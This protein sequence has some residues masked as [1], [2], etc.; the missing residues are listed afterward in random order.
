MEEKNKVNKINNK[1]G[2]KYEECN[3]DV[4]RDS[5]YCIFH[6]SY[7]EKERK[8][9]WEECMRKFYSLIE[10]DEGNFRGFVLKNMDIDGKIIKQEIDFSGAEFFGVTIFSDASGIDKEKITVLKKNVSFWFAIFNGITYFRRIKFNLDVDFTNTIFND[11]VYLDNSI[12]KNNS[13]FS[14]VD[15]FKKVDFSQI[16]FERVDFSH[17][18]FRDRVMFSPNEEDKNNDVPTFTNADFSNSYFEK[19]GSFDECIIKEGHFENASIQNI[20]F[21]NVNLDNVCFS[22][23]KMEFAYLADSEWTLPPNRSNWVRFHDLIS[24][25][26]PRIVI[27]EEEEAEKISKNNRGEKIKAL[28]NAEGTYR[29]I[30][31]SLH[32]EGEYEKAGGFYIHEMKMKRKRYWY[33]KGWNAKWNFFWNWFYSI[34][35]GYSERPKRLVFNALIIIL[36]FTTIYYNNEAIGKGGDEDYIPSIRECFYFSVVT[37]TTLGY[38]DYSPKLNFQL[39][40]V[41]EAFLGAFTIALFV[42]VFGRKVMR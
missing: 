13:I 18:T 3:R 30:K 31:H 39:V 23:A 12:F 41:T 25:S 32:N 6:M 4:E 37:F 19:G 8:G 14:S 29:L 33:T 21:R 22:G 40:A 17:T 5:D 35:C 11:K 34:T 16:R 7:E 26:D 28:Q 20:S 1:D 27:K 36:I 9:L 24:V 2:C 42:L 38:G 10:N 15:F